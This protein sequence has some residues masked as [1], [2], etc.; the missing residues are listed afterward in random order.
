LREGGKVLLEIGADQ[1]QQGRALLVP[2]F[3]T[4]DVLP[5]LAGH[6]RV[7]VLQR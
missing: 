2:P 4:V 5:D 3:V 1:E 7:V 6:P